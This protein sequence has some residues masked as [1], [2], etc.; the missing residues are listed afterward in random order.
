MA[1]FEGRDYIVV[2]GDIKE[3]A[4]LVLGHRIILKTKTY[5]TDAEQVIEEI[6]S[7][8]PVPM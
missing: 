6:L 7:K 4:A 3:P 2:P 5:I 8:I 1:Y